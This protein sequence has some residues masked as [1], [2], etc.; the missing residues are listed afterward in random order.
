MGKKIAASGCSA[1]GRYVRWLVRGGSSTQH[2]AVGSTA[3]LRVWWMMSASRQ[4]LRAVVQEAEVDFVIQWMALGANVVRWV[5]V[6][7]A[8]VCL[9]DRCGLTTLLRDRLMSAIHGLVL[10]VPPTSTLWASC[11]RKLA[12]GT[13][14]ACR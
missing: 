7:V 12:R 8:L 14:A 13:W 2:A 1:L 6:A 11:P 3:G 4:P 5:S 10:A 9:A